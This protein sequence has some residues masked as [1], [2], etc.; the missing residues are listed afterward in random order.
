MP[1]ASG[2]LVWTVG[3]DARL[4]VVVVA[5][6]FIVSNDDRALSPDVRDAVQSR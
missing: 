3:E 4:H 6:G 1:R 5:I 2:K